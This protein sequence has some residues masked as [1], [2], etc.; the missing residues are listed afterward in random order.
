M[1]T[2]GRGHSGSWTQR[3][4]DTSGCRHIGVDSHSGSKSAK[5]GKNDPLYGYSDLA[6]PRDKCMVLLVDIN[7]QST[8]RGEKLEGHIRNNGAAFRKLICI[9][10][11]ISQRS[12]SEVMRL[13][14]FLGDKRPEENSVGTEF[15][16][17]KTG[18]DRMNVTSVMQ[19][20]SLWCA[21][22]L[23]SRNS[24]GLQM[25][26]LRFYHRTERYVGQQR[27]F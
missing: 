21:L 19:S 14:T 5:W 4:V 27:Y 16:A 10:K 2:S 3:V 1:D 8:S 23:Q 20:S 9:A 12:E 11:S 18:M 6:K 22:L 7:D 13:M 17:S 25:F 24:S 26:E 15:S